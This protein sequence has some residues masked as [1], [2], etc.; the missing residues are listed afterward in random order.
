MVLLPLIAL[1]LN[2][3]FIGTVFQFPR[4]ADEAKVGNSH[5]KI[6]SYNIHG[7]KF[8]LRPLTVRM[9]SDFMKENEVTILCLQE[10]DYDSVYTID[11]IAN[12]FDYLPYRALA[13]SEVPGFNLMV[14]SKYPI[15]NSTRIRF[16][17]SA[18]Q[19]MFTDLLIHK[20]TI[21]VFNFHLQTTNFNQARFPLVPQSWFWDLSGEARKSMTVY[22]V[23]TFNYRKR[24]K[25]ANYIHSEIE[26]TTYPTLVCGDMN[27]IP[28]SHTYH[29]IKGHHLHDGFTTC[30]SGYEYTMKGLYRLYRI[31][32]IFHTEDFK[33]Y[34]YHSYLLDYSDHKPVIMECGY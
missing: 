32:Y 20:D 10:V 26:K 8:G 34:S 31:D 21:R 2:F 16:H 27:S 22:D 25:Q 5:I 28:A 18:N 13:K 23:L 29:Q 1:I 12:A 11:S 4:K 30:G 7:F 9:I 33:G 15:V 19:A 24:I 6:G 3:G 14:L 17:R